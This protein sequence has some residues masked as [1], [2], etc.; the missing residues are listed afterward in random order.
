LRCPSVDG[1]TAS[2][3]FRDGEILQTLSGTAL[4]YDDTVFTYTASL[5][6]SSYGHNIYFFSGKLHSPYEVPNEFKPE[7][8]TD[9][10][11]QVLQDFVKKCKE[12]CLSDSSEDISQNRFAVYDINGDGQDELITELTTVGGTEKIT[13]IYNADGSSDVGFRPVPRF[14]DNGIVWVPISHNQGP[15]CAIWPF[16]LYDLA[17]HREIGGAWAWDREV[18]GFPAEADLDGD[19]MVYYI[20]D[21]TLEVDNPVDNDVYEAWWDSYMGGAR[22]LPVYYFHLSEDIL[23]SLIA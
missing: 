6:Y 2:Y 12:R 18:E 8:L 15:A 1:E 19:G 3:V 23:N 14:Y 16:S 20:G 9:R 21:D 10:Q 4:P 17:S 11:R 13:E 7:Q 22:I 5:D